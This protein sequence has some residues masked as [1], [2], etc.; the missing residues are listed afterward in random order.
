MQV[1]DKCNQI[2][3]KLLI[4]QRLPRL[5]RVLNPLL[6]L[7]L[8]AQGFKPLALQIE[9]VLLAHRRTRCDTSAAQ[10]LSD[11]RTQLHFVVS[12]KISLPH[13]VDAHLQR[14][15]KVF[16]GSRNIGA[17]DRRLVSHHHYGQ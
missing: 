5:Q 3:S 8:A 6:R 1:L 16:A 14:R 7:L 10:D 9:N 15:Q 12:D 4:P 13:H 17:G 11:L 2:H